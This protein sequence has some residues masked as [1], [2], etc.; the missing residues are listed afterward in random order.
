MSKIEL[1]RYLFERL[2]QVGVHTIFGLPGDFNL[3]LLDK[4]YEV[5]G[6]RWA[7]DTNELNAAYAADG[8]ARVK[9]M[10]CM[11]TTFGV[12]E[13]SAL[14]GIAG[15]YSEHV[16][17][18]H[19]VG[20]PSTSSQA[21]QLLLHHTLGNGDFTVFHRMSANISQTTSVI[22][23]VTT[24]ASEI[25]R[26]IRSTYIYQ[27]P[28][29]LGI[30]ANFFE[31]NLP[32]SLLDTP[33]DL[34]LRPN[35]LEAENECVGQIIRMIHKAKSPI[36]ISDACASRHNVKRETQELID[37][38]QFPAFNTPMGKGT[39]DENHP[40]YGG[41][42]VGSLSKQ[43]I[44]QTVESADLI[45]SIGSLLSDYNTGSFSYSYKTKNMVEFHSD[46]M[47]IK[48]AT[49]PGVQ[50]KFVLQK[51]VEKIP[52][53]NINY[54]PIP[55]PEPLPPN[56]ENIPD[57]TPLKQEWLWREL[58]K[59]LIEGDIVITETGTSSF[60][61]NS[62]TFPAN[63]LGISQVLWGSIGY[64]GGAVCG[65]T[66]A[67]EE[68]DPE[69]RVILF[70]GDGSLQLTVQEISTMIRWNLHPYLFILNNDG[71]TIE[72]LIHGPEAAYNAIQ[73]WDHLQLL[74]VFGA[75]DY[76]TYRVSTVGEWRKLTNDKSFQKNSTIRMIEIM[77][78]VMDAPVALIAQGKLSEQLN[79]GN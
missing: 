43:D 31:L 39:I 21:K 46:H 74:P 40:R 11:V 68:L 19:V 72:R 32:T 64:A 62:T 52:H 33:I 37:V 4:L 42:Y 13:L 56:N 66:F 24:A 44:K 26:C 53:S 59:F 23:D 49:F 25:D 67:A 8:Y 36:I 51:L 12:G 63:T 15:S 61:I 79:A 28:V 69:K 76:E 38:T 78:P 14:N 65:A 70:I 1:G 20:V 9:G 47:K 45:L 10:A 17:V 77:L 75:T 16:G 5:E 34:S 41:I 60:G 22:T 50:M 29:Y 58:S 48:N 35:D 55:I 54:K 30:P 6:M 73:S 18:L 71:Y 2:K 57:S 3:V 7:G 27:R